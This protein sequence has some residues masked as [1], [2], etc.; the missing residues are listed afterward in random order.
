MR[1]DPARPVARSMTS[2]R[3]VFCAPPARAQA[4]HTETGG[5]Q[6]PFTWLGNGRTDIAA[7]LPGD[8]GQLANTDVSPATSPKVLLTGQVRPKQLSVECTPT[9]YWPPD[10]NRDGPPESP[11]D[12]CLD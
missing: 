6:R 9:R 12:Q 2:K 7:M 8:P 11:S 5:E 10:S 1:Q 4:D 3:R